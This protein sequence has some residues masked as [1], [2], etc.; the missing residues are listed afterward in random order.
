MFLSTIGGVNY[1]RSQLVDFSYPQ[2]YTG[3]H[4]ISGRKNRYI[5][6]DLVS[7]VFDEIS[8]VLIILA[9][10]SMIP[11]VWFLLRKENRDYSLLQCAL[12]LFENAMYQPL[13]GSIVPQAWSGRAIMTFFTLYNLSLNLMY[14]SMII[15]LLISGSPPPEIN[16]LTDLNKV[17]YQ[18]IRI[19]M[20]KQSYVPQF[21]TRAN[22]IDTFEHR[23]DY[24]DTPDLYKSHV[25][26]RIL[27]GSHIFITS[28]GNFRGTLCQINKDENKTLAKLQ[29]FIKSRQ[30][31]NF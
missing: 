2:F 20:T 30:D 12:H 15:S 25:I 5:H 14:M 22:M 31:H 8:F 16:S 13:N 28:H 23:I 6:A 4:I 18:E 29:D 3:I 17:E 21:L 9:L 24:I 1:E 11:I 19:F 27:D 7:G 26:E 10:A